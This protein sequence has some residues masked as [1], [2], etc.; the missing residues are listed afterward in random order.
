MEVGF[1]GV[2]RMG[3]VMVRNL[4]DAGHRVRA[5]DISVDALNEI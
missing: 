3:R 1:I 5:W 2:G 4:L